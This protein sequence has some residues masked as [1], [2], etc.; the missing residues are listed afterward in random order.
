MVVSTELFPGANILINHLTWQGLYKSPPCHY[1]SHLPC[2]RCSLHSVTFPERDLLCRA[3]RYTDA[4]LAPEQSSAN[5]NGK[6][7]TRI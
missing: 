7:N 5:E 1:Q 2:L 6:C 4:Q 3:F